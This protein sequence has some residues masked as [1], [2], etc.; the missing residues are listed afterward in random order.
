MDDKKDN[1]IQITE[2]FTAKA[3][4]DW[5]RY[6]HGTIT[7]EKDENGQ[8]CLVRS[9]IYVKTQNHDGYIIAIAENQ[10]V[11]GEKLDELVLLV[12]D[13][14]INDS[15]GVISKIAETYIYHN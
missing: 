3:G 6:F 1:K 11:V 4:K 14:Q 2:I 13:Y 15:N 5:S 9:K 10:W 7:R 8:E 12:L